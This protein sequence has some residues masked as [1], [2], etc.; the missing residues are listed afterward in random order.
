MAWR[1]VGGR[2][3]PPG[4][5]ALGPM[6]LQG[7]DADGHRIVGVDALHRGTAGDSLALILHGEADNVS[8]RGRE[9]AVT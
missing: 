1:G 3:A 5:S 7:R 6:E 8:L 9:V 2:A 4:Q